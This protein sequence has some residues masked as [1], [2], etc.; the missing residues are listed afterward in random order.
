MVLKIIL[1]YA[2]LISLVGVSM[3]VY[4][5]IAAKL[6]PKNRISERSLMTVGALGGAFAMLL[7]ML[8]IRHKTQHPKFMIGL[9]AIVFVHAAAVLVCY[10]LF[11]A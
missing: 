2:A 3:T 8:V 7:T 4:D 11:A 5:K 1:I 10:L 9:P 6:L